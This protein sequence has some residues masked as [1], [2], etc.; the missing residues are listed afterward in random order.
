MLCFFQLL[1][2]KVHFS[3]NDQ[4]LSLKLDREKVYNSCEIN[5]SLIECS[6]KEV[7]E[8]LYLYVSSCGIWLI[9]MSH[10]VLFICSI[11]SWSFFNVG[12]NSSIYKSTQSIYL[13]VG[14]C[15]FECD[16]WV[17]VS[18]GVRWGWWALRMYASY[19]KH[20]NAINQEGF[21]VLALF[22]W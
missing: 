17:T 3:E 8:R 5:C 13:E 11:G 19:Y 16:K 10:M 6:N 18:S 9:T 7:L 1:L 20:G 14:G 2:A 22:R 15:R 12:P 4:V 21:R